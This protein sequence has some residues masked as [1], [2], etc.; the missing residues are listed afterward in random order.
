MALRQSFSPG[1]LPSEKWIK[2]DLM[3]KSWL[4]TKLSLA[5]SLLF[6]WAFTTIFITPLCGA[7]FHCGC[8]WLWAGGGE[9]CVGMM[10]MVGTQHH[11]PWCADA[12]WGF[13][14]PISVIVL[15]Q[16]AVILLLWCRYRAHLGWQVLVGLVAFLVAS[17]GEALIHGWYKGYP[18]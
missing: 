6:S 2:P 7:I 4:Y 14:I 16:T 15:T 3:E 13:W 8:T 11:C 17:Y 1:R 9:K 18:G 10:D 12:P 5:V